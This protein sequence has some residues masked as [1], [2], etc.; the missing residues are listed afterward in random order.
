[1]G[2]EK[3]VA[4]KA[5][6]PGPERRVQKRC[7]SAVYLNYDIVVGSKDFSEGGRLVPIENMSVSGMRILARNHVPPGRTVRVE[8]VTPE[9]L[10]FIPRKFRLECHVVW[11][12]ARS[13]QEGGVVVGMKFLDQTYE[14]Q[15]ILT[16]LV[17]YSVRRFRQETWDGGTER[18]AEHRQKANITCDIKMEPI[19]FIAVGGEKGCPLRNW[20]V[21][22][23]RIRTREPLSV[24][25][26]LKVNFNIPSKVHSMPKN[27]SVRAKVV[28]VSGRPDGRGYRAGCRFV[29]LSEKARDE[30][31][32]ATIDV[33]IMIHG[34][35]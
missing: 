31:S 21:S 14:T 20:S 18:R 9:R 28:W 5:K 4:R 24:G 26:N 17:E 13:V 16:R 10:S 15:Q 25:D 6:Y 8:F 3:A 11:A 35:G 22:G 7:P 32:R 1:M 2:S 29:G 30:L 19:P 23:M 34:Y 12:K 33:L 27:F